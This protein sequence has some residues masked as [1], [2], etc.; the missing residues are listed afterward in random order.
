MCESPTL[1]TLLTKD[2]K[3]LHSS[4]AEHKDKSGARALQDDVSFSGRVNVTC[5]LWA[6]QR[7]HVSPTPLKYRTDN[8][9]EVKIQT[10]GNGI[11]KA[12]SADGMAGQERHCLLLSLLCI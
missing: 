1:K 2:K 6:K 5:T 9:Y 3:P 11:T 4:S 12:W 10:R 8:R 7:L